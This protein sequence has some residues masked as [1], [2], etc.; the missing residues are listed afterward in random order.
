MSAREPI[1]LTDEQ[2]DDY[3]DGVLDGAARAS[4]D[5]HLA[6]CA[7]C[8]HALDGTRRLLATATRERSAL[9]APEE[10]WPLV[11]SSTIHLASVRRRVVR[12]MRGAL[13]AGAIVVA[14]ATAM[15]TWKIARW[16]MPSSAVPARAAPA[17]TPGPGEHAGH[18]TNVPRAPEAPVAPRAPRP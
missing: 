1:H 17:R 18:P 13:I 4:A 12:S 15:V 7:R 9:A 16:T 3:A 11:A 14:A 6:S 2:L 10:L 5:A 8:R